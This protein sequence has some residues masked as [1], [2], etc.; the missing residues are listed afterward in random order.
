MRLSQAGSDRTSR[1]IYAVDD[2]KHARHLHQPGTTVVLRIIR[3]FFMRLPHVVYC[4]LPE[5]IE[6]LADML[7]S[8]DSKFDIE[9]I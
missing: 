6:L 3:L 9:V 8:K 1:L 4:D 7:K 2:V 5:V